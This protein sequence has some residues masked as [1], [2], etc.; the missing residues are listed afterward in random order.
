MAYYIAQIHK[1]PSTRQRRI[2]LPLKSEVEKPSHPLP[3][4][5]ADFSKKKLTSL[6]ASCPIARERLVAHKV[7]HK[8]DFGIAVTG[9][10]SS[11]ACSRYIANVNHENVYAFTNV[12]P[13]SVQN[14][15]TVCVG[16]AVWYESILSSLTVGF[17][18]I[19]MD[20]CPVVSGGEWP[21][22]L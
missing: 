9:G 6:L 14:A 4:P 13:E 8:S 22:S 17:K 12:T 10:I 5:I 3:I 19:P 20:F 16:R 18:T 15:K 21:L 11:T 7:D 1:Y 2:R